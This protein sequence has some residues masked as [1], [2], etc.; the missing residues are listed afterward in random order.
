M[1][2]VTTISPIEQRLFTI[3]PSVV[4][5]YRFDPTTGRFEAKTITVRETTKT[6]AADATVGIEQYPLRGRKPSGAFVRIVNGAFAGHLVS[7]DAG[8]LAPA[9]V[10]EPVD[11]GVLVDKAVEPYARRLQEL[12]ELASQ[13]V[14]TGGPA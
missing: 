5:G 9:P 12:D 3:P 13:P 7:A 2:T 14:T 10:T 1:Q 6:V 8:Q 4:T 11:C